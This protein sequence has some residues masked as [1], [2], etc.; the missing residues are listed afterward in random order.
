MFTACSWLVPYLLMTGS[1]LANDLFMTCYLLETCPFLGTKCSFFFMTHLGLV[2]NFFTFDS[3]SWLVYELF[4]ASCAWLFQDLFVTCLCTWTCTCSQLNLFM[5]CSLLVTF[6]WLVLNLLLKCTFLFNELSM[7]CSQIV[8][9]LFIIVKPFIMSSCLL[10]VLMDFDLFLAAMSSSRSGVVTHFVRSFVCPSVTKE[11][12]GRS[13]TFI[14]R[15]FCL[16][17]CVSALHKI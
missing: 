3:F 1:R 11:F 7:T 15:F 13:A 16:G 9:Y 2:Q 6:S 12:L 4:M 17:V 5:I 8:Y 10:L 14:C